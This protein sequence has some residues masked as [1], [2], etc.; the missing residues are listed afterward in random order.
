MRKK[1]RFCILFTLISLFNTLIT[2]AER[3]IKYIDSEIRNE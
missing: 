1:F 3:E 2:N